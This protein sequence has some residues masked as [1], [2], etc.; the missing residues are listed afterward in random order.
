MVEKWKWV[1]LPNHVV[2]WLPELQLI[3]IRVKVEKERRPRWLDDYILNTNNPN[4]LT[5]AHLS[6]IQY[7]QSF[8]RVMLEIVYA[9]PSIGPVYVLKADVSD[10]FYCIGLRPSAVR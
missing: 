7:V 10:V 8:D 3:Q 2:R 6:T 5:Q 1:V 4:T 9:E